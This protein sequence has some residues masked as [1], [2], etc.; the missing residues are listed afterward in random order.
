[1]DFSGV[2]Q[3]LPAPK[4]AREK[5]QMRISSHRPGGLALPALTPKETEKPSAAVPT[6]VPAG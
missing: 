1:M 4:G 5:P 2:C 6:S 3:E